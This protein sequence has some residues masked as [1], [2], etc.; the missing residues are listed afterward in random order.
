MNSKKMKVNIMLSLEDKN[1]KTN[2]CMATAK[3]IISKTMQEK[4][5]KYEDVKKTFGI[6]RYEK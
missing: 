1:Q 2:N 6:K 5:L 4:N 3:R